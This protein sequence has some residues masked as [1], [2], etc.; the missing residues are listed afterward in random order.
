M[1]KVLCCLYGYVMNLQSKF[2]QKFQSYISIFD[3]HFYDT[4]VTVYLVSTFNSHFPRS[5]H[6][7]KTKGKTAIPFAV[8]WFGSGHGGWRR[9]EMA[10]IGNLL[11]RLWGAWKDVPSRLSSRGCSAE[12]YC[13]FNPLVICNTCNQT[14]VITQISHGMK[15]QC[16]KIPIPSPGSAPLFKIEWGNLTCDTKRRSTKR[17]RYYRLSCDRGEGEESKTTARKHSHLFL[18]SRIVMYSVHT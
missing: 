14:P 12:S 18:Y 8:V 13:Q 5:I 7:D 3:L 15:G 4:E 2:H 6:G 16:Y 1:Y 11:T 9:R 17:E 10:L